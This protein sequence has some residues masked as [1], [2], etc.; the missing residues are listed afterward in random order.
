MNQQLFKLKKSHLVMVP[1]LFGSSVVLAESLQVNWMDS[2]TNEDGFIIE[3]RLVEN[4]D[5]QPVAFLPANTTKYVDSQVAANNT[6]CYRINSYNQAG[7]SPSNESCTFV[8]EAVEVTPPDVIDPETPVE[9]DATEDSTS[10]DY[11]YDQISISHE[12]ITKPATIEIGDKELYSFKL[13]Q[14]FNEGYSSNSL[15]N[16]NFNIDSGKVYYSNSSFSFQ[17]NAEELSNGYALMGFNS[18]NS[19]T[20]DLTGNGVKQVATLYMTAGVWS[21][22]TSSVVINVG[23][24]TEV[25]E[26]SRGYSWESFTVDIEF[27]GTVP[28]T[29][30]TDSDVGGYSGVMIAG[31]VLNEANTGATEE[32]EEEIE[33]VQYASI[34]DVERLSSKTID[35]SDVKF[36]TS[37]SITGNN[38]MSDA[39]VEGYSFNGETWASQAGYDFINDGQSNIGYEG[40]TWDEANSMELKLKSADS[41]TNI[42]S[43]YFSAGAWTANTS[44]IEVII[45]GESNLVELKSG[46]TWEYYKVDVE[47]EGELDVMIRPV[48]TI[49]KVAWLNGVSALKFVGVTLD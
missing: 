49:K 36:M 10:P 26:I 35:V 33:A 47:F 38:D 8:N 43:L 7:Q 3:K 46:Y 22:N 1:F 28:V 16:S 24:K 20:F 15:I 37:A 6:Y 45:N 40:L 39:T 4:D 14:T 2:S 18:S 19:L 21:N 34:I 23:E 17:S 27:D 11:N 48:G 25:I 41:Q 9:P 13:D 32:E 31:L 29:V 5:F 44:S 30:T 42:A 12:I